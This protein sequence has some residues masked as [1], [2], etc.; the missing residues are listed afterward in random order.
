MNPQELPRE[1]LPMPGEPE[2]NEAQR[3][4]AAD[5]A[6]GP[7]GGVKGPFIPLLRSPELMA[8][9]GKVGEYLRFHGALP[10]KL[11]EFAMLIVS[12]EW[13]CQFEW[14]VHHPLAMKQGLAETVIRDLAQGR[15]PEGMDGDEAMCH[16]FCVELMRTRGVS[17]ETYR[18]FVARFGEQ[19]LVEAIS[20][21]G[22]FTT[23]CMVLNVARTPAPAGT[24]TAPLE[25]LPR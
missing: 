6:A 14:A 9:L 5:L 15:R 8:H 18:A 10:G 20:L 3:K 21:L 22:Y 11:N 23:M 25:P 7:R 1:R 2:M 19:A 16:D 13:T 17:D 12:R 4:A 24:T